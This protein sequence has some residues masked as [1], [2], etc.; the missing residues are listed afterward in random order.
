MAD[1]STDDEKWNALARAYSTDSSEFNSAGRRKVTKKIV[2]Q[3][4]DDN[5]LM[6]TDKKDEQDKKEKEKKDDDARKDDDNALMTTQKKTSSW[7]LSFLELWTDEKDEIVQQCTD[8]VFTIGQ[9]ICSEAIEVINRFIVKNISNVQSGQS[10]KYISM[11]IIEKHFPDVA[12]ELETLE[13]QGIVREVTFEI[14][15]EITFEK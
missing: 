7:N 5:A 2:R 10:G 1:F 4:T 6:K 3:K 12:R 8:K 9:Y 13:K 11:E 15:R 14:G